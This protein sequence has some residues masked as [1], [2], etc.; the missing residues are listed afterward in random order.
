MLSQVS[1]SSSNDVPLE[2]PIC[3]DHK[4]YKGQRGLSIHNSRRHIPRTGLSVNDLPPRQAPALSTG[5]GAGWTPNTSLWSKL[6]HLKHNVK[7]ISRI[8]KGARASVARCLSECVAKV[9][10]DNTP[11]SWENLLIF[12][13]CIL[14]VQQNHTNKRQSLTARIKL[15]TTQ[16]LNT[17]ISHLSHITHDHSSLNNNR[18]VERKLSEGNIKGAAKL[19]FSTDTLAIDSTETLAALRDKHPLPSTSAQPLVAP[20]SP[21]NILNID[22]EATKNGILSFP[23]GSAGGLDG[24]TPQHLKDLVNPFVGQSAET[25][26]RNLTELVKIMLSGKVPDAI[27]PILYGA[28][29]V[30]LTKKDGGVRPIAVGSTLRRLV[31]KLCCRELHTKLT[32]KFQPRQLGFGVRGGCE[33]AVHAARTFL[34][35]KFYDVFVKIDV[36]NAFN[37]VDRSALLT[38]IYKE[39]PE[40]SL[41]MYQCYGTQSKLMFG[42]SEINSCVGCQQ[43]DPLGPAI[44]S[45]AIQPFITN[46]K[47]KFNM[48]YLDDGSLGG[49][50]SSVFQDLESIIHSFS[51]IGLTLN[52]N[53]CEIFIP[54][55]IPATARSD[56]IAK[57]NSLTPNIT[58]LTKES[59]TLL[60]AP[61]FEDAIPSLVKSKL[62]HFTLT[63][64]RLFEIKPHMAM[65]IVRLCLFTPKFI[66][67]LRCCPF[68]K[69]P[70]VTSSI[71]STLR[72]TVAKILNLQFDDRTWTQATLPIIFG[73]LGIRTTSSL[74]LP[75]FLS[76]AH[77]TLALISG[78]L[79]S[80][81]PTDADVTGLSE[82]RLVWSSKYPGESVPRELGCQSNWDLPGVKATHTGLLEQCPDVTDRA[83]LLAVSVKESGH[84]LHALP[85]H[86]LGTILDPSS[87]RIAVCLRLGAKVCEPHRCICGQTVDRLGRHGLAC[88]KSAGRFYRHGT[89]ND[90]IRRA[91][92]TASI[93]S[94]LEPSGMSR[95]DGKRPDGV[96]LVPWSLGRALVWDAT[97]VDTL[98][99]SYVQ[100]TATVAGAAAARAQGLKH[101]N[102]SFIT[103]DYEFAALA[104]ETLGPWSA[105]TKNFVRALSTRL[106]H[107]SGDPR[108]GAYLAQRLSIA[109]QRGNGA[110][111]LGTMPHHEGLD[112][113]HLL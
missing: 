111:V 66:Y 1:T 45:L 91:L 85:S 40:I 36:K 84:W 29:L 83:R 96:T 23:N 52:F 19:L 10:S 26:V 69:F 44:F 28:N 89:I 60:G 34:D 56:I 79:N 82:A 30:A 53:K 7:I 8:P 98:A 70:S 101:R 80:P 55:S 75:A 76:S 88:A 90:I 93:P 95:D 62:E 9:V 77:S 13:Y 5:T 42:D 54:D 65:F 103:A 50:A 81:S 97:C 58:E 63:S 59:L 32:D 6:A 38:E 51:Q 106:V 48:W 73:G 18:Y 31:S 100:G 113:V 25:L 102:Y 67:L 94:T 27:T 46:L 92:A 47:S 24:L 17:T 35:S 68:W 14:H 109:I 110:S 2:C 107:A 112:G 86:N 21:R 11:E 99:P 105:D 57:F 12:P 37:S 16:D 43:G 4:F 74:A 41:Y 78:I 87:L 64:R 104:V 20:S 39:I 61:I 3:A 108:A 33:A 15:N 22:E 49:D 71:D 72:N